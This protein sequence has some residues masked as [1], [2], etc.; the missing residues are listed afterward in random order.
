MNMQV[1]KETSGKVLET[2]LT[3]IFLAGAKPVPEMELERVE[4]VVTDL[5]IDSEV[6]ME[7]LSQVS[8]LKIKLLLFVIITMKD[9][10]SCT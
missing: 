5:A 4:R 1:M 6:A 8:Y 7:V 2:V 10:T 9:I 3:E